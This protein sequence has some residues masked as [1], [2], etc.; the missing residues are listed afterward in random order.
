[1]EVLSASFFTNEGH[2][3]TKHSALSTTHTTFNNQNN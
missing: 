3:A 2:Y 1:M